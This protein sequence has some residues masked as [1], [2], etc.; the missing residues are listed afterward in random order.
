[1]HRSGVGAF[2]EASAAGEYALVC[3]LAFVFGVLNASV[4]WFLCSCP[5]FG[6]GV[7]VVVTEYGSEC[8]TNGHVASLCIAL[9]DTIVV[10]CL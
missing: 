8:G 10:L 3:Y 2:F 1:M 4:S 6:G 5:G 7:R 9:Y